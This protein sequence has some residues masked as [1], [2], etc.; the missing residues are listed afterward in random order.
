[1][2]KPVRRKRKHDLV[3]LKLSLGLGGPAT[4]N[5]KINRLLSQFVVR[6]NQN[7]PRQIRGARRAG[8]N[9]RLLRK[10][11]G[12]SQTRTREAFLL[13]KDSIWQALWTIHETAR[14]HTTKPS[15]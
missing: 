6:Q 13:H 15:G 8:E 5:S 3:L 10:T 7:S 9:Y 12:S 2:V 1:M 4:I 14:N 11:P